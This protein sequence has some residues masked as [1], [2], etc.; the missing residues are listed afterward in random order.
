MT[1]LAA[2]NNTISIIAAGPIAKNIADKF[3]IDN[4]KSASILDIFSCMIQGLIPYGAQ[5]LSAG[6]F[7][8]ISPV[9]IL[10]YSFYP[11]LI[12]ICGIAAIIFDCR[13]SQEIR[14]KDKKAPFGAFSS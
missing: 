5:L 9:S 12:G 8:N 6:K 7:G 2:A 11:V 14:N 10:P 13:N 4:R 1:N 3:S